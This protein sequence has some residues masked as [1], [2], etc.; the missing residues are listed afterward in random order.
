MDQ[1]L[2]FKVLFIKWV[3]TF[4]F[5]LTY[6]RRL[7]IIIKSITLSRYDETTVNPKKET[8]PNARKSVEEEEYHRKKKYWKIWTVWNPLFYDRKAE[9]YT[10]NLHIHL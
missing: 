3:W 2:F 10:F 9:V 7:E 5:E 8:E 1:R 6:L 4:G